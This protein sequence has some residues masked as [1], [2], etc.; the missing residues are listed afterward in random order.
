MRA[1]LTAA[2]CFVFCLAS[3]AAFGV[4]LFLLLAA[5]EAF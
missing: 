3:M 1:V 2:A 5:L 4:A